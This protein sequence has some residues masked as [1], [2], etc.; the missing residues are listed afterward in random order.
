MNTDNWWWDMQDQLPAE[1]KHL[2]VICAS[3]KTQ[4]TNFSEDQR[5]WPLYHTISNS[6][7]EFCSKPAKC[8][9]IRVGLIPCHTNSATETDEAWHSAV[10]TGLSQLWNVDITG[11]ALKW[12]CANGFQRQCYPILLVWVGDYPE[13]VLVPQ[14]S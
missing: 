14:V 12:D 3:D 13:Q 1:V 10:G 7:K 11:P 6:S 9:G 8:A 4:L 2:P 5:V